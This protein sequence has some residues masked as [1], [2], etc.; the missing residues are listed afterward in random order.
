MSK[1]IDTWLFLFGTAAGIIM[2]L[3]P[4]QTSLTI[5]IALL[6]IGGL[7]FHPVWNFWWIER[8]LLRRCGALLFLLIALCG[9]GYIAWPKENQEMPPQNIKLPT[10][11]TKKSVKPI[12]K[13]QPELP[14]PT[15][16]NLRYVQERAPSNKPEFLYG[17]RV[18]IQSTAT[19]QTVYFEIECDGEINDVQLPTG[20]YQ[21]NY[22]GVSKEKNNIAI[23]KF[24]NHPVTPAAPL[25]VTL[26]SKT[27]IRVKQIRRL[28][29]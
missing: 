17:L 9:L 12:Y 4:P 15:I 21:N 16:E 7:L 5:I 23:I 14:P 3:I 27:D 22:S 29:Q 13:P 18:I 8:T 11:K 28:L 26:L 20:V 6:V 19:L 10:I 1:P 24:T 25:V 2:W